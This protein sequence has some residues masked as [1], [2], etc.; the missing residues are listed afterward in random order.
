MGIAL[1]PGGAQPHLVFGRACLALGEPERARVALARA[2][3]LD[4]NLLEARY[5]LGRAVL[6]GG[7]LPEGCAV[8]TQYVHDANGTP[9]EADRVTRARAILKRFADES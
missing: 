4:P 5:L 1:P 9:D 3:E 7:N 8:L 6:N 2:I